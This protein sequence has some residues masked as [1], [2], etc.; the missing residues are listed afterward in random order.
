[1]TFL[2]NYAQCIIF[3]LNLVHCWFLISLPEVPHMLNISSICWNVALHSAQHS[4]FFTN[5]KMLASMCCVLLQ[6]PESTSTPES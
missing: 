3:L 4:L 1:M 5:T 2:H 6:L